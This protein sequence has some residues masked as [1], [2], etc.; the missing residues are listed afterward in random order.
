MGTFTLLGMISPSTAPR[1]LNSQSLSPRSSSKPSRSHRVVQ[2]SSRA[3]RTSVNTARISLKVAPRSVNSDRS[4]TSVLDHGAHVVLVLGAAQVPARGD[5]AVRVP[6]VV[7]AGAHL[8]RVAVPGVA[9]DALRVVE[10]VVHGVGL[11]A[12]V[13]ARIL[14]GADVAVAG[15]V[16]VHQLL[17]RQAGPGAARVLVL[18]AHGALH[19][20][21]GGKGPAGAARALVLDRGDLAVGSSVPRARVAGRLVRSRAGVLV[22][23]LELLGL[24]GLK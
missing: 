1:V 16:A 9:L 15:V 13:A 11:E 24:D 8:A 23:G 18:P 21:A 4:D 17:G 7:L 22:A 6:R 12:A 3:A 10:D 2:P 5:L 19:G 20:G 14:V